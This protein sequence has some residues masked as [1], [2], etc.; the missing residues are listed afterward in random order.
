MKA[1][2]KSA[3]EKTPVYKYSAASGR[4]SALSVFP[5]EID[6]VWGFRIGAQGPARRY[7][8]NSAETRKNAGFRPGQVL[9]RA[10]G[11][12][13]GPDAEGV[14]V[15]PCPLV[16][17]VTLYCGSLPSTVAVHPRV[18]SDCHFSVHLNHFIPGFLSYSVAV[19]LK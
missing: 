15:H 2:A 13:G 18:I 19:F 1:K 17:Q 12:G 10:R 3:A 6:F 7:T 5:V 11:G 16:R 8:K 9:G 4:L 14:A